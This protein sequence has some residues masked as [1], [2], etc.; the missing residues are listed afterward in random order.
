MGGKILKRR[1]RTGRRYRKPVTTRT[2]W[3]GE[4]G[5]PIA[6]RPA[7][8][9]QGEERRWSMREREMCG[10]KVGRALE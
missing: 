3:A 10:W 1:I 8:S 9:V 7:E 4:R 2:D 5:E 6:R